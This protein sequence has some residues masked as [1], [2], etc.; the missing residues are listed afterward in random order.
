MIFKYDGATRPRVLITT[1]GNN[2]AVC[3]G[4]NASPPPEPS[5]FIIPNLV[6]RRVRVLVE[7]LVHAPE[8]LVLEHGGIAGEALAQRGRGLDA[9]L[10]VGVSGAALVHGLIEVVQATAIGHV[11][12]DDRLLVV[13]GAL[14]CIA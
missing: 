1:N 9:R 7:A 6:R 8:V 4:N 12:H 3:N 11:M 2:T 14:S 10:H 5:T 13:L